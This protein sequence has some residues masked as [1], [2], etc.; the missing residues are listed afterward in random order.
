MQAKTTKLGEFTIDTA[1]DISEVRE[2]AVKAAR[3]VR[4]LQEI[5][6]GWVAGGDGVPVWPY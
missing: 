3:E 2:A 6:M 4:T 5:E 1:R